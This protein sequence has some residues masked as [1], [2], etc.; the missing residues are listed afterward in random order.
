MAVKRGAKRLRKATYSPSDSDSSS[1][2]DSSDDTDQSEPE[3]LSSFSDSDSSSDSYDID[4]SEPGTRRR[5]GKE[6]QRVSKRKESVS[7]RKEIGKIQTELTLERRHVLP[8]L[9]QTWSPSPPRDHLLDSDSDFSSESE[10]DLYLNQPQ[11]RTQPV[12]KRRPTKT[13][14]SGASKKL[15]GESETRPKLQWEN[16]SDQNE[17]WIDELEE[18]NTD[19]VIDNPKATDPSTAVLL[20]LLRFQK[21]WLT[22]ALSQEASETRGGI[23]ADEMGMGKT[24]QAISLVLTAR[25]MR[26]KSDA[27][28][29]T[30]SDNNRSTLVICPVVAV[31]QWAGEIE[32]HTEKGKVRVLVYHGAKRAKGEVDFGQ[33]DFVITTY[34]TIESDYRKYILP[35]KEKCQY[36]GH[37]FVSS[38]K[39]RTHQRYF[40]EFNIMAFITLLVVTE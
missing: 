25:D 1:S 11:N 34:S 3:S 20:P 30:S 23:L 5:T 9:N 33:Y 27:G 12:K 40:E 38:D 13:K 8:D 28:T 37:G 26:A 4:I 21:E 18:D 15:R 2:S 17:K 19:R 10:S 32:R 29:S 39:L 31:I 24:I 6:K 14:I 16:W 7:N 35:P 36:C 22:W